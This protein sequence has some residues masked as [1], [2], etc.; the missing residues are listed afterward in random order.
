MY[1]IYTCALIFR[2]PDFVSHLHAIVKFDRGRYVLE[3]EGGKVHKESKIG[4]KLS[5]V[6]T[7]RV[8]LGILIMLICLPIMTVNLESEINERFAITSL[9]QTATVSISNST[10]RKA[11]E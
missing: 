2:N 1:K 8:I 10:V 6:T 9:N 11:A 7:A 5:E 4:A 3:I